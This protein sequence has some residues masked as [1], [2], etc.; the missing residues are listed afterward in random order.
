VA[1]IHY[2]GVQNE[3]IANQLRLAARELD[4]VRCCPVP[5]LATKM[6]DARGRMVEAL[7]RLKS[8][9]EAWKASCSSNS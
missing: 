9:E 1:D 2:I 4:A 7:E 5:D 8:L 6:A 3:M